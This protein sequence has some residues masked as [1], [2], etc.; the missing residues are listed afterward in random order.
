MKFFQKLGDLIENR[1]R[2]RNFDEELF[3][4]IASRALSEADTHQ[5][6]RPW[7]IIQWLQT[8]RQLPAQ[9][10]IDARFGN[11]PV[12]VYR[13]P[14]FFIAVLY[15]LDG[16]T[17]IHQHAFAGA[18]QVLLGSSLHGQYRFEPE[19]RINRE[20]M[21]GQLSLDG[22]ELLTEGDVR[23]IPPGG[24]FIHSLFHLDRPSATVVIRT[25]QTPSALPQYNYLRPGLAIDPFY[26]EPSTF[27]KLQ[28]VSLL[29]KMEHPECASLI[30]E[31]VSASDFLTTFQIL[32][33]AF[34]HHSNGNNEWDKL[35]GFSTGRESLA[36]FLKKARRR[37]G[38]LV[39][40][41][42]PVF[43]EQER[44]LN[45]IKR[46]QYITSVEHRFFL[47]LLLNAPGRAEVLD[48]VKQRFPE[49]EAADTIVG[50]VEELSTTKVWGSRESNVLGLDDVDDV[51]LWALRGLLE[52][53]SEAQIE[54]ALVDGFSAEE[55]SSLKSELP[56]LCHAIRTSILFK[57]ILAET[58]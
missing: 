7:D 28:S 27:R 54:D 35:F 34:G 38:T 10:D 3:P 51:T 6:V 58:R 2:D 20:L 18:F 1:W 55:A 4:D 5:S 24:E 32:E 15:W 37:H 52:G 41:L 26:K 53:L 48:L 19:Q 31:L 45:I 21:T 17:S 47:A 42:P 43:E 25:Y 50:W 12:T 22:M 39:D 40:L 29:L 8:T 9:E 36:G 11:P 56:G 13:S 16:T 57:S 49:K 14:R 46:R 23:K 44:Q 33:L 30:G